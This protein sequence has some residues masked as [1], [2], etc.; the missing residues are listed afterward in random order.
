MALLDAGL[1]LDELRELT[2]LDWPYFSLMEAEGER[3]YLPADRRLQVPLQ[4]S[5][6]AHKPG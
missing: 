5:I 2:H 6:R 1:V 3:W 4:F